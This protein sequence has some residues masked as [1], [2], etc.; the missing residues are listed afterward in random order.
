M[1]RKIDKKLVKHIANP[2]EVTE[3]EKVFISN[4]DYNGIEFPVHKKRF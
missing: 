2:E 3:E 4:L 1:I